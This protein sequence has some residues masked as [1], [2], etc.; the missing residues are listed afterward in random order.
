VT[1]LGVSYTAVFGKL[2]ICG[3]LTSNFGREGNP[4]TRP[5]NFSG[6]AGG[7]RGCPAGVSAAGRRE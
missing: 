4:M 1:T 5:A 6:P 3:G 7:A 2:L